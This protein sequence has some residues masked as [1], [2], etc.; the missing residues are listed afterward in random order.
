MELVW[1]F[2]TIGGQC[3]DIR[4]GARYI[5]NDSKHTANTITGSI[6]SNRVYRIPD[7]LNQNFFKH[8]NIP[9]FCSENRAHYNGVIMSMM[10]S[11]ITSL[12]V[13]YLTVYTSADQRKHQ[14]S[15]SLAFV[16]GIHGDR[17]IPRTKGQLRGK[18]FHLMTS[19]WII[20]MVHSLQYKVIMM[21]YY[22]NV[23]IYWDVSFPGKCQIVAILQNNVWFTQYSLVVHQFEY[24]W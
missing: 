24:H 16:W 11:Q 4:H 15:A 20:I 1:W 21:V 2:H 7:C 17:W 22:N 6:K 14:S 13:V 18:C 10:A 23:T 19:S 8:W 12:T 5:E 3:N 9:R